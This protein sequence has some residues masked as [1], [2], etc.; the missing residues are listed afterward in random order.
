MARVR[1]HIAYFDDYYEARTAKDHYELL[2]LKEVIAGEYK[3]RRRR[4]NF[5]LV[6]RVVSNVGEENG[7]GIHNRSSNRRKSKR[8]RVPSYMPEV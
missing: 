2:A 7:D 1:K 6:S 4:A 5:E 8:K 3:I